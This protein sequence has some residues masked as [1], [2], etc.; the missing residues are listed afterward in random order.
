MAKTASDPDLKNALQTHRKQTKDHI[1]R[2]EKTFQ[3]LGEK[4][5]RGS[6]PGIDGLLRQSRHIAAQNRFDSPVV[7]ASLIANAQK[8]E[9]YEIAAYGCVRTHAGILGYKEIEGLANDTLQEEEQADAL[10]T[11]IAEATVNRHA[12]EAPYAQARTGHR[13]DPNLFGEMPSASG[14]LSLSKIA[15]GLVVG[16]VL[17]LLLS[18]KSA[19]KPK[20][21]V[22]LT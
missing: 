20:P 9:H 14:K 7:D 19:Q 22:E 8:I 18:S 21:L 10:L 11:K 16:G 13:H 5:I 3:I 17:S 4:P 1:V 15:L 6:A 2:L 12:A